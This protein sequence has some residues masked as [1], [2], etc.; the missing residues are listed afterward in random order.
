MPRGPR[1][2]A[3][4]AAVAGALLVSGVWA[5]LGDAEPGAEER[6]PDADLVHFA[7]GHGYGPVRTVLRSRA[8]VAAFAE[9]FPAP[10]L[11]DGAAARLARRDFGAE[12]LVAF[13]WRTGCA[14]AGS[15]ALRSSAEQGLFAVPA[16]TPSYRKCAEPFD[17]LAVFAVPRERA[18]RGVEL[19]GAAPDPPGPAPATATGP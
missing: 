9:R 14:R 3:A 18:P 10:A 1:V 12:A 8:D 4:G 19:R 17:A 7:S 5:V 11:G 2:I 6:V 15:A 13:A 16:G